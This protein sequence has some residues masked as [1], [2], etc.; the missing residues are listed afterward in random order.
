LQIIAAP[1]R[2]A[3]RRGLILGVFAVFVAGTGAAAWLLRFQV[4]TALSK[5]VKPLSW[6][7]SMGPRTGST[8]ACSKSETEPCPLLV[9]LDPRQSSAAAVG[10]YARHAERH[11]WIVASTDAAGKGVHLEDVAEIEALVEQVR[12]TMNV[13]A[14]RVMLAG[15]GAAG[16]CAYRVALLEPQ[17]F[18]GAI[19]ECCGIAAWRDVVAFARPGIDMYLVTRSHDRAG[20]DAMLTMKDEMERRGVRVV[21]DEKLGNPEEM[22][23]EELEPPFLWL[24]SLRG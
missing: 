24:D 10:R 15:F 16:E 23:G 4:P 3:S 21:L 13:N 12:A 1:E 14:S 20:R 5:K 6:S 17:T 19:A 18:G 22:A 8:F 2:K 9:V 11:G 7:A